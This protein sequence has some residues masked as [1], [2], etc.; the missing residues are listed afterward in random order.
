MSKENDEG[1]VTQHEL[2]LELRSFKNE[3]RLLLAITLGVIKFDVPE[4]LTAGALIVGAVVAGAK[5][6]LLRFN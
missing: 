1:F 6:A 5:F 3:M 2:A 4:Q